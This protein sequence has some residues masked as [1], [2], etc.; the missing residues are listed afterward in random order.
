MSLQTWFSSQVNRD[1]GRCKSDSETEVHV[2]IRV[3]DQAVLEVFSLTPG[4]KASRDVESF[5][6]WDGGLHC[7][8]L[9]E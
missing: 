9:K 5:E 2:G 3:V 1:N 8:R 7:W 4:N 6:A